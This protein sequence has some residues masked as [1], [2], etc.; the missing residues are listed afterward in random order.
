[1][2]KL[3]TLVNGKSLTMHIYKYI[4]FAGTMSMK[5]VVALSRWSWKRL[6]LAL[7][8]N[9]IRWVSVDFNWLLAFHQYCPAWSICLCFLLWWHQIELGTV[10][11]DNNLSEWELRNFLNTAKKRKYLGDWKFCL[12]FLHQNLPLTDYFYW[13]ILPRELWVLIGHL[14]I[15][16]L[17][18]WPIFLEV[19]GELI[20]FLVQKI[21][22]ISLLS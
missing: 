12:S 20:Y 5:N 6:A 19:T 9:L 15:I 13:D 8:W 18:V 17:S 22:K 11:Q 16:L 1:M 4:F 2:I 10:D 7:I 21:L 14:Y 3:L